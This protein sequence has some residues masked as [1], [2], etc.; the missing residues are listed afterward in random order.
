MNTIPSRVSS[1]NFFSSL[2]NLSVPL[3]PFPLLPPTPALHPC[4]HYPSLSL[5]PL[6]S[7]SAPL[8]VFFLPPLC[9][10]CS[11]SHALSLPH[12]FASPS[13][14]TPLSLP[15]SPLR[16]T[17]WWLGPRVLSRSCPGPVQLH[18]PLPA[19]TVRWP[20]KEALVAVLLLPHPAQQKTNSKGKER[21]RERE[22]ERE[23]SRKKKKVRRRNPAA[24]FGEVPTL[25]RFK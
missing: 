23:K 22:R 19:V 10:A 2:T 14:R 20:L 12:R 8:P 15:H 25:S 9:S 18:C 24:L 5:L 1:M 6:T 13:L 21:E 3:P 4:P 16:D 11:S 7:L 17:S